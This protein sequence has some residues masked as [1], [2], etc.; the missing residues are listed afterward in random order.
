MSRKTTQSKSE[1]A[2]A[3]AGNERVE[4]LSLAESRNKVFEKFYNN[5]R[6]LCAMETI[7]MVELARKLKL[8]SGKRLYDLCYGRGTPSSEELIVLTKHF[9]ITIDQLLYKRAGIAWID[10]QQR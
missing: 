6:V 7:S 10:E 5:L 8:A 2:N 3:A 1:L 9:G 4:R